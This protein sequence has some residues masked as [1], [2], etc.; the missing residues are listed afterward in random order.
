M[1]YVPQKLSI[2]RHIPLTVLEFIYTGF[3]IQ[4]NIIPKASKALIIDWLEKM[5][6]EKSTFE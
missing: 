3:D 1:G 2:K 6:L 5:K 4:K